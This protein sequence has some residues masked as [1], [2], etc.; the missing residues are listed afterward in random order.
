M[1]ILK[2]DK[3]TFETLDFRLFYDIFELM[4]RCRHK[5][6][7]DEYFN[8][9]K[10]YMQRVYEIID[11]HLPYFWLFLDKN[12]LKP[13]GFCYLYDVSP[14]KNRI[15]SANATI[16]FDKSVYGKR[17]QNTAKRLLNE[18]F[19]AYKIYK[20]KAECYS[21]NLLIPNFLKKLGFRMEASLKNE[22]ISEGVPKNLDIWSIFNP[23]FCEAN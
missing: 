20:I 3:K 15:H 16:C 19:Q 22:V 12:T 17:A 1:Q 7:D 23:L 10:P 14:S 21:D 5:L 9:E 6:F 2:L 18:L 13:C 8:T 4:I 11:I